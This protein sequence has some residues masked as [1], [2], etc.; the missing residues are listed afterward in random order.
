MRKIL[1]F[2][3]LTGC[4][5]LTSILPALAAGR[6]L[7]GSVSPSTMSPGGSYTVSCD[8]GYVGNGIYP[9]PGSGNCVYSRFTGTAA[10]FNCTAGSIGGTFNNSCKLG[11]PSPY[12]YTQNAIDST[13]VVSAIGSSGLQLDTN[14]KSKDDPGTSGTAT[15]S[16]S[17]VSTPTLSGDPSRKFVMSYT[18]YGGE[19]NYLSFGNDTL[20]THFLYDNWVYITN[21]ANLQNLEMD[22]NQV[23]ANGNTV[24]YGVQCAGVR[25]D[26]MYTLNTGT[27]PAAY[28][29]SW[30]DS[31]VACTLRNWTPNAWHHVQI[32]YQRDSIGNVTYDWVSVDGVKKDFVGAAGNS[33]FTLGW[34]VGTLLTN[35][36]LDGE[37]QSGSNVVYSNDLTISRW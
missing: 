13:T 22:M 32:E 20:S 18:D 15:G 4:I 34:A 8:Y 24:I 36:Q 12:P 11:N 28:K 17:I 33:A 10:I 31:N 29:D 14:W 25:G 27:S 2:T 9:V 37:G 3:L 26:W 19:L 21:P 35:L 23:L 5:S 16:S 30:E 7:E 6:F 1:F